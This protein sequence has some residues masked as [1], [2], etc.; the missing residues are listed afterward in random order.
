MIIRLYG[1]FTPSERIE[2]HSNDTRTC[3]NILVKGEWY[4]VCICKFGFPFRRVFFVAMNALPFSSIVPLN[5]CVLYAPWKT[6]NANIRRKTNTAG[7][8]TTISCLVL[9]KCPFIKLNSC[10]SLAFFVYFSFVFCLL[11]FRL[12]FLS[13]VISYQ[14][15]YSIVGTNNKDSLITATIF[16]PENNQNRVI[17]KMSKL[18]KTYLQSR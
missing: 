12:S 16:H 17:I 7:Y 3:Y 5:L 4:L 9:S 6:W 8:K 11:F 18:N 14:N 15:S 10:T 1:C 2:A 13:C